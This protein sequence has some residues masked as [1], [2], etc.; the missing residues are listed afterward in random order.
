[1]SLPSSSKFIVMVGY[2]DIPGNLIPMY[3]EYLNASGTVISGGTY[4]GFTTDSSLNY[5]V[6]NT[7]AIGIPTG[8]AYDPVNGLVWTSAILYPNKNA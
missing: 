6:S 8:V 1:M 5:Q 2:Q 4:A 3:T 7:N